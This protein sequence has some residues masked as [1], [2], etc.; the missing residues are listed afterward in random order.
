MQLSANS[1]TARV[2]RQPL[3]DIH[4]SAVG[5]VMRFASLAA[6]AARVILWCTTSAPFF[7]LPGALF[8]QSPTR[9]PVMVA[10]VDSLPAADGFSVIQR[11]YGQYK[12]DLIILDGRYANGAQL[13]SAVFQLMLARATSGAADQPRR[14]RMTHTVVPR[15]W[16]NTERLRAA[17]YVNLLRVAPK[18]E[19]DGLGSVRTMELR[20]RAD[21]LRRGISG[22]V[23]GSP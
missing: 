14:F 3:S 8:A 13:A 20:V 17:H 16:Q 21:V 22:T 23:Y 15:A 7:A 9:I 12:R 6:T 18:R 1:R 10:L 19:V 2:S 4:L 5:D 11:N